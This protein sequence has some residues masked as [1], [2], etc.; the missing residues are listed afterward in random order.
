VGT[1]GPRVSLVKRLVP[2]VLD[3][4]CVIAF[5]IGGKS[6]H[7]SS[8]GAWVVARIA[9]PYVV[10]LALGWIGAMW[11]GMRGLRIWPGGVLILAVTYVL[12]MA[13]RRVSGHGEHHGLAPGF[14]IVAAIF[15]AL[16]MLGWRAVYAAWQRFS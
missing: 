2:L 3:L 13:L 6:A 15:L 5:A 16:T 12:G 11:N 14:L 9:W 10:A 7:E 8:A 1:A 4:V